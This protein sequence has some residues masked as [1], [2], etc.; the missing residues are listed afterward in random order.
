MFWFI[1][2]RGFRYDSDRG[3]GSYEM[4]LRLREHLADKFTEK[5]PKVKVFYIF[6]LIFMITLLL[7]GL[8]LANLS[9]NGLGFRYLS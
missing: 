3:L 4:D 2:K 1:I 9:L 5:Y 6:I 7:G 8:T